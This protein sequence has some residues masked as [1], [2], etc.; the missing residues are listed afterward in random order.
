MVDDQVLTDVR[1]RIGAAESIHDPTTK[2]V[3][4]ENDVRTPIGDQVSSNDRMPKPMISR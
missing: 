4:R 1:S 2:S 3:C